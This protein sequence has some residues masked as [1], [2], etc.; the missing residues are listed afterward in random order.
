MRRSARKRPDV[1]TAPLE[2]SSSCQQP[3]ALRV[4]RRRRLARRALFAAG[5]FLA[6]VVLLALT[7]ALCHCLGSHIVARAIAEGQA[8]EPGWHLKSNCRATIVPGER[9]EAMALVCTI[10]DLLEQE[11]SR[12]G[13]TPQ[14]FRHI[15][16]TIDLRH[17]PTQCQLRPN[18]IQRLR[19]KLA[20]V[21]GALEVSLR[22]GDMALPARSATN[23]RTFTN[24]CPADELAM[25]VF[26][27]QQHGA[28]LKSEQGD[29]DSAIRFCSAMVRTERLLGSEQPCSGSWRLRTRYQ[30]EVGWTVERVLA[31]G[32]VDAPPLIRLQHLLEEEVVGDL[33][34]ALLEILRGDRV[35][36]HRYFNVFEDDTAA[37]D[38]F[39]QVNRS[40]PLGNVVLRTYVAATLP[41]AHAW[42]I[43]VVNKL[44][45]H[46]KRHGAWSDADLGDV[47]S[48]AGEQPFASKAVWRGCLADYYRGLPARIKRGRGLL[49]SIIGCIAAERYRVSTGHWPR[50]MDS[51]VP[52]YL[53]EIPTDPAT[54]RP[55]RLFRLNDGI[56]VCSEEPDDR[57][58]TTARVADV[59]R[60]K[61]PP[62]SGWRLWDEKKRGQKRWLAIY[63]KNKG[64]RNEWH[65]PST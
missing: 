15:A 62:N 54:G 49:L 10:G 48:G 47:V 1:P 14:A 28:L 8:D 41:L 44:I 63:G 42:H 60:R 27:L 25:D 39:A 23:P 33:N 43:Q 59:V 55:L 2:P 35:Y 24:Q 31:Q 58:D 38:R 7:W 13:L 22:L 40:G 51:L 5:P 64:A 17:V 3:N 50:S 12:H 4:S 52:L 20:P 16:S 45:E 30:H 65:F 34:L 9:G 56:A 61:R 53:Q 36:W 21:S 37:F 26:G 6:G 18:Q 46:V 32:M 29:I 57:A 19:E 11:T